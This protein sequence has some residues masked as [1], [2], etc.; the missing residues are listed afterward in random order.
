MVPP[1]TG[2][3]TDSSGTCSSS[4][5]V[6]FPEVPTH[7]WATYKRTRVHTHTHMHVCTLHTQ[8]LPLRR[9][10]WGLCE[11]GCQG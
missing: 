5:G 3:A 1:H 9:W 7:L 10:N 2:H 4:V 6:W 8:A 11:V